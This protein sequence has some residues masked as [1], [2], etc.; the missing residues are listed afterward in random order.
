MVCT[1][2]GKGVKLPPRAG[3]NYSGVFAP[4]KGFGGRY[5]S[6]GKIS[7]TGIALPIFK[8]IAEEEGRLSDPVVKQ[9]L[10]AIPATSNG[11]A[12]AETI[13]P[14]TIRFGLNAAP[15]EIKGLV[16]IYHLIQAMESKASSTAA[17]EDDEDDDQN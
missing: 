6:A 5:V 12:F 17:V 15:E 2:A 3:K 9:L 8:A 1:A 11:I 13:K 4:F 10:D 7:V 14:G 16:K